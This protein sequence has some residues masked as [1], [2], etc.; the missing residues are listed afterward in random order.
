MDRNYQVII[1]G[2]GPAGATLAYELATR[3]I[4]VLVLEKARLPRFKSCAG[5]L[6][7]KATELL[8]TN[9][10]NVIENVITGATVT[11][12]GKNPFHGHSDVPIMYTVTRENFDHALVK[13]AQTAG[14]EIIQGEEAQTVRINSRNVE[15]STKTGD[16]QGEFIV[17]ADGATSRVARAM[18]IP[19][20]DFTIFGF[21]CEVEVGQEDMD[22]WKSQIGIDLGR[23]QGYGWV[24]PKADH[25][26]IGI[27]CPVEK[28]KRLKRTFHEYLDSLDFEQAVITRWSGGLLPVFSNQS[29]VS[30]GR[31]LLLG[32][33]AG[34]A[35]PLSGEGIYNAILSAQISAK[36]IEKAL[37]NSKPVLDDYN[38]AIAETITPQMKVAYVFS[39]VLSRIPAMLFKVVNQD[40]RV[41]MACCKML[42]GEMDYIHI[43]NRVGSLGGLYDLVSRIL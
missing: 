13:R 39:K 28:A 31:A 9:G 4:E 27:A 5:G 26:S 3:G 8:G 35:D 12:K 37:S 24:F 20:S 2:A 42:R 18:G 6:T 33:A 15:V 10:F 16:Y 11:F 21:S 19:R 25:L 7:V 17:G 22:R 14:A 38:D 23:V 34:L 36:T 1:V 40:E 41:W 30:R 32:D 29:T 43:K